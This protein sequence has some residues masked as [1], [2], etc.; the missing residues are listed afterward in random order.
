MSDLTSEAEKA[1]AEVFAKNLKNLLLSPPMKGKVI[2]GID[3][4]FQIGCKVAIISPCG[5]FIDHAVIYPHTRNFKQ[6]DEDVIIN[7]LLKNKYVVFKNKHTTSIIF[8]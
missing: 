6:S 5:E 8:K 7:M 4:G 2:M 1:S 3:P